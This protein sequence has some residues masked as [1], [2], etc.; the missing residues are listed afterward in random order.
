MSLQA[1]DRK[2][3]RE[4]SYDQSFEDYENGKPRDKAQKKL[5]EFTEEKV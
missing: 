1:T 2:K 5:N 4:V 3:Q